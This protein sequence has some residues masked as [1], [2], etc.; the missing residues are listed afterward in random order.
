MKKPALFA[1]SDAPFWRDPYI[2]S[3][4][5]YVHLDPESGAASYDHDTIAAMDA[6]LFDRLQL[7]KGSRL[8]DLGCGP[9]LHSVEFASR[10]V[11]V[12]GLDVSENS[13][14]YARGA[15]ESHGLEIT[16]LLQDY[17][18]MDYQ[19]AFDAAVMIYCDYGVLAPALRSDLLRR[20]YRALRPGGWFA[21]D[22]FTR[23]KR[24]GQEAQKD[25]SIESQGGFWR[26]QPHI[27]LSETLPYAD[28][29]VFLD[30]YTVVDADGTQTH[31]RL[32]EQAFDRFALS[33]ELEAAGFSVQDMYGSLDGKP[34]TSASKTLAAVAKKS[35]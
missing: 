8:L 19:E 4:M 28:E 25:W 23:E 7:H 31:Y 33:E 11:R 27:V 35:S 13:L 29:D 6:F 34:W 32:W 26:S 21:L 3:Q 9:G 17:L 30:H 22:V 15:A 5:L 14:N 18:R 2:A 10:G 12:T 16:Y 1:P 20:I 24:R